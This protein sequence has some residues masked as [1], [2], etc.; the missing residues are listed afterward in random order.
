MQIE[1]SDKAKADL[2]FWVKS[3]NKGILKKIYSLIEDIQLHPF[4]GIG[5]PEPL[6]H[7]LSGKWSRRINQEHRIIYQVTEENTI[8][9]LDILSLKGHYE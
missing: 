3:G 2:D 8:E 5:K 6:K 1:F 9:I 7:Q 4:E